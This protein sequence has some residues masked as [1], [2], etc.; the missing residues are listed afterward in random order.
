[1]FLAAYSVPR[2]YPSPPSHKELYLYV[3]DND[4]DDLSDDN[5]PEDPSSLL[6]RL[7]PYT[8]RTRLK[9]PDA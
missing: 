3:L 5:A 2:K 7:L 9:A 4:N 6:P 1:M 8:D